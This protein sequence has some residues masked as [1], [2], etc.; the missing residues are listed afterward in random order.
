MKMRKMIVA[1][2]LVLSMV[3]SFAGALAAEVT[4]PLAPA[5]AEDGG[6]S[7]HAEETTWY[8][9][10]YNGMLQKRLW[11]ITYE[12]WLTDWIDVGPVLNP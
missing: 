1:L 2:L 11:S 9:R 3:C 12:R 4:A 10:V 6:I 7:P 5:Q 8:T